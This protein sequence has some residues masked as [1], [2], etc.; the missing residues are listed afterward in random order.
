[1]LD[2][3]LGWRLV[4]VCSTEMSS[5][6]AFPCVHPFH[7]LPR[8]FILLLLSKQCLTLLRLISTF[9]YELVLSHVHAALGLPMSFGIYLNVVK[10]NLIHSKNLHASCVLLLL[11]D[12]SMWAKTNLSRYRFSSLILWHSSV[13]LNNRRFINK[14]KFCGLL[15]GVRVVKEGSLF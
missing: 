10:S 7:T 9:G 2:F 12:L 8:L 5:S 6:L 15:M 4:I 3:Y 11:Y 14:S 13:V 1:M